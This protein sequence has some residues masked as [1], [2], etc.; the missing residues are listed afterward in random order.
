MTAVAALN[1]LAA[2]VILY[3]QTG[4]CGYRKLWLNLHVIYACMTGDVL[5][6]Q[7]L[8]FFY[9]HIQTPLYGDNSFV[10]TCI[11][12]VSVVCRICRRH[13]GRGS[14]AGT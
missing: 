12:V 13:S 10:I 14:G 1:M 9:T 2:A 11:Y 3:R 5:N 8:G 6:L 7:T 4:G